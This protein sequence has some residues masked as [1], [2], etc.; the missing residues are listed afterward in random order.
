MSDTADKSLKVGIEATSNV[1]DVAA[2]DVQAIGG[3]TG[4]TDKAAEAT[5]LF[6]G[7]GRELHRVISELTR[8]SPVLGEAFR[9]MLHPIGGTVAAAIGIFVEFKKHLDETNKQLDAMGKAAADF[10]FLDQI[11]GKLSVFRDAATAAQAYADKLEN[12]ASGEQSIA[13]KLKNQLELDNAIE[14]A[15][16]SLTSAQKGL[17]IA[18]I[19]E[20]E[21]TGK[22][23][24][25]KAAEAKA[26]VQKKYLEQEQ[27][28]K[29]AAQD[30]ELEAKK[31]AQ[32][33]AEDQQDELRKKQKAATAELTADEAHRASV[34]AALPDLNKQMADAVGELERA[35]AELNSRKQYFREKTDFSEEEINRRTQEE[36]SSV[37]AASG[38]V[39]A[40]R[41]RIRQFEATQTPDSAKQLQ[42]ERDAAEQAKTRLEEN[43]KEIREL[44]NAIQNLTALIQATRP[45]EQQT[46]GVKSQTIDVQENERIAKK[47]QEDARTIHQFNATEAPSPELVSKAA[48]AIDD[49]GS[50]LRDHKDLL[51]QIAGWKSE[52]EEL[53]R[54]QAEIKAQLKTMGNHTLTQG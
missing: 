1:P 20:A 51:Y 18:R 14:R 29:Q 24:A 26:A 54:A 36:Q 50:I 22:M 11:E 2:K 23:T 46:T 9:I 16:A 43:T 44:K 19:Q 6:H 37:A 27:S 25:E 48:A 31:R 52:I 13:D 39:G 49:M 35:Q 3:I 47:F 5:K 4:S 10:N 21:A 32:K 53:K 38:K 34:K 33:I 30:K 7:E 42:E 12:I 45:I 28:D 17:D 15:R 41:G 40:I 8:I